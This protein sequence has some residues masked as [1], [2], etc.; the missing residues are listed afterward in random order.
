MECPTKR[1]VIIILNWNK[2]Q[3]TIECLHS[4]YRMNYTNFN[5]LVIDNASTD[6]SFQQITSEFP[7]LWLVKNEMNTGFTGG[8]NQGI[9]IALSDG[10]DYVWLLNNDTVVEVD[11]LSKLVDV[12]EQSENVGMV[13]PAIYYY[14]HPDKYQFIGSVVDW[15][16]LSVNTPDNENEI[17]EF[18]DG[19][20]VCLWGTALLIKRELI[21][22]IG[23]LN[24]DYFAYYEDTEYS[25]RSI[26]NG[27]VNKL[28][29][30]TKIYHKSLPPTEGTGVRSAYFYYYMIRNRYFMWSSLV[31]KRK[32]VIEMLFRYALAYAEKLKKSGF[33]DHS[34]DCIEALF[35][36]LSRKKGKKP[37]NRRI[38]RWLVNIL[39]WHPYLFLNIFFLNIKGVRNQILRKVGH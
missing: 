19:A 20:N 35:D 21:D 5:V 29:L 2:G 32:D 1:V 11:T 14:D 12:A 7:D 33:K 8:N 38:P 30:N 9:D 17:E 27:F 16:Q 23:L 24:E 25:L 39:T 10:A 6:K 18:T 4:V 31:D 13:S 37:V 22:C 34:H 26:K 28:T 36:A 3:D 15:T